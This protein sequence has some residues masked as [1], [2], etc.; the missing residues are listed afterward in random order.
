M[1][2][3]QNQNPKW[4][5]KLWKVFGT[6]ATSGSQEWRTLESISSGRL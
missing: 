1:S 2:K 5:G 6:T 3:N 4:V